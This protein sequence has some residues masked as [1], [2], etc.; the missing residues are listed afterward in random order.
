MASS[1]HAPPPPPPPP[2]RVSHAHTRLYKAP[3]PTIRNVSADTPPSLALS[4]TSNHNNTNARRRRQPS[5]A[6]LEMAAGTGFRSGLDRQNSERS[7]NAADLHTSTR[8]DNRSDDLYNRSVPDGLTWKP[9]SSSRRRHIPLGD[10]SEPR[11]HDNRNLFVSDQSHNNNRR[12]KAPNWFCQIRTFVL[13]PLHLLQIIA[14]VC[15]TVMIYDS[16]YKVQAH[17]S[18]LN[19][20]DEERALMLEQMIWMDS[21]AKVHKTTTLDSPH[22]SPASSSELVKEIKRLQEELEHIQLRIQLNA[23]DFIHDKFGN[24]PITV[25]LQLRLEEAPH[26]TPIV[27]ELSDD[28]PHAVSVLLHQI[29]KQEWDEMLFETIRPG[30]VQVSSRSPAAHPMLEF[31]EDSRSCSTAGSVALHGM[32]IDE[33]HVLVLRVYLQDNAVLPKNDVCIGRVASGVEY[34]HRVPTVA[35]KN[36]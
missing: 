29:E 3:Q 33:V 25:S 10:L 7:I 34:L 28:T 22:N 36:E 35:E 18:R 30:V 31:V 16:H 21:K 11:D 1:L 24:R 12:T 27:L 9:P 19:Q 5:N 8:S 20:F 2:P 4:S 15:L 13:T 6:M 32:V 17:K 14:L 26:D 23:R